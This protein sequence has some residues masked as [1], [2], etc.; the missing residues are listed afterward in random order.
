M[1]C[2]PKASGRASGGCG[3]DLPPEAARCSGSAEP[4]ELGRRRREME[5]Q[6]TVSA[7]PSAHG[8]QMGRKL[9]RDGAESPARKMT[10]GVLPGRNPTSSSVTA[11]ARGGGEASGAA[12]RMQALEVEGSNG[13]GGF[14]RKEATYL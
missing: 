7:N 9:T 5:E 3:V 1:L 13:T 2:E 4:D 11:E 12:V 6:R 14:H 8:V 10:A